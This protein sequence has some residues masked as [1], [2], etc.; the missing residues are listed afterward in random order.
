MTPKFPIKVKLEM[1][2]IPALNHAPEYKIREIKGAATI[3]VQNRVDRNIDST[4]RVG[5]RLSEKQADDLATRYEVTT[6]EGNPS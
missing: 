6:T 4:A 3:A 1:V 5:D 2:R